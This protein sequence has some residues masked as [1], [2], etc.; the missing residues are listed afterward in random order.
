MSSRPSFL[1][2]AEDPAE[3]EKLSAALHDEY[4][5]EGPTESFLVHEMAEAQ[6]KLRRIAP[7]ESDLLQATGAHYLAEAY[8][9][10]CDTFLKMSRYESTLRRNWYRA[11]KELRILRRE[12]QKQH[13]N[14]GSKPIDRAQPPLPHADCPAVLTYQ[15]VKGQLD[16]S[17][18]AEYIAKLEEP[19]KAD[20]VAL[21]ELIRK[22]AP[23]LKPFIHAGMLAYGPWHYKYGGGREGDWFRIGLASNKN[24]ISLYVCPGDQDGYIPEQ[25]KKAL[26]KA[27]IGRSCVRFKRLSDLD[28]PT[29]QQL[30]RAGARASAKA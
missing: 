20:I 28:L 2:P 16:V 27:S 22:N 18:P 10:G 17:T 14:D 26:P 23:E 4:K 15:A 8:A 19:R 30:I 11:V 25:Y 1:L 21:D 29:L 12:K 3:F 9:K 7:V 6:W 24:Y 5:P 13:K